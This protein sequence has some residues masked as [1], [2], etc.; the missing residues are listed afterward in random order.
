VLLIYWGANWQVGSLQL[1]MDIQTGIDNILAGPYMSRLAQYGAGNATRVNTFYVTNTSPPATFTIQDIQAMLV[2]NLNSGFLPNPALDP[3]FLYYVVTQPGATAAEGYGGYHTAGVYNGSV[4]FYGAGTIP[5]RSVNL[6]LDTDAK[7]LDFSTTIFS[8]EVD[9]TATDPAGNGFHV[10]QGWSGD[11]IC[12]NDGQYF[13]YRLNG[14][15][16]QSYWSRAD[17][18]FVLPDGNL[19]KFVI[20]NSTSRILIVAGDQ[21]FLNDVITLDTGANGGVRVTLNG[22]V[23]DFD[24]DVFIWGGT[25]IKRVLVTPGGGSNLVTIARTLSGIPTHV[26]S[27]ST[28]TVNIGD[29]TNGRLANIA[30]AVHVRGPAGAVNLVFNDPGNARNGDTYTITHN[31]V[32]WSGGFHF[33]YFAARS[34][35][36]NAGTGNNTITIASTAPNTPTHVIIPQIPGLLDTVNLGAPMTGNM[37]LLRT[38]PTGTF[39]PANV[40]LVFNDQNN[41]RN[42][43][44]TLTDGRL[45]RSGIPYIFGAVPSLTLN[46]GSGNNTIDVQAVNAATDATIR[47][48][49]GVATAQISTNPISTAQVHFLNI[50]TM[51][52][53]GGTLNV[54]ADLAVQRLNLSAGTLTGPGNFTV[55][56]AS[57][58]TGGSMTGNGQTTL[59]GA[60]TLTVAGPGVATL[61]TRSIV[62]AGNVVINGGTLNLV[63]GTIGVGGG[64]SIQNGGI[65]SG[66]GTVG[67]NL[68]N[69]GQ[70]NPGG[71][72]AAG[73]ITVNGNYTQTANGVLNMDIGGLAANQYDRLAVN[74]VVTLAGTLN[75]S[76]INAYMPAVGDSFQILTF[77]GRNGDFQTENGL[78]LGANRFDPRYDATS[79]TLVVVPAGVGLIIHRPDLGANDGVDWGVLGPEE[80]MVPNPFGVVSIGGAALTVSEAPGPFLRLDEGTSWWGNFALGD[81]LLYTDTIFGGGHGPIA[82][83]FAAPVR[84]AGAQIQ[85]DYYGD[86][87]ARISAYDAGG[88][89]L[90]S[91]TEAG[92]SNGNED[93]S[94]IFIGIRTN[95]ANITTIVFSM[96]VAMT[97]PT[98]FGINRLDFVTGPTTPVGGGPVGQPASGQNGPILEAHDPVDLITQYHR[99]TSGSALR[100]AVTLT[101][102]DLSFSAARVVPVDAFVFDGGPG[103]AD[104]SASESAS[105]SSAVTWDATNTVFGDTG[106]ALRNSP[107]RLA[108]ADQL[109]SSNLD[110]NLVLA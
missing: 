80:T 30:G 106:P 60:A 4:I 84:G 65:L 20:S 3:Q 27:T 89:L 1:S 69:D 86:F 51:Q 97:D 41:R 62:G 103:A 36:L 78:Q 91:F 29:P 37:D 96:D 53:N 63:G 72:G 32:T 90:G 22:E 54:V 77:T 95:A 28:D 67:T 23:A 50:Q 52:I 73:L 35:V 2:A 59:G 25:N 61:N 13:T 110:E 7:R 104:G 9:E 8:H 33:R 81:H 101:G 34:I 18:A 105:L 74:G 66:N 100:A 64:L 42:I 109:F 99:S 108:V 26:L 83:H 17:N 49:A 71:I 31:S 24:H 55:S 88:N 44:Y 70:V 46:T 43:Q 45:T 87:V 19:Q 11:E 85:S 40:N 93:N 56:G 98:D 12:D 68:S 15:M 58:W 39:D 102:N 82:I 48:G 14:Y 76:L 38:P 75:V 5:P 6:I 47:G 21:L 107:D 92:T 79:L 57:T 16:V 94:A 10:T